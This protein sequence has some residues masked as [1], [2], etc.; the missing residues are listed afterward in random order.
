VSKEELEVADIDE[1]E[2]VS[3]ILPNGDLKSDLKL[4]KED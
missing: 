3:V 4:P 1:D 2:F